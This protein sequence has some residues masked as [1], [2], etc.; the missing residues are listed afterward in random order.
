M[1]SVEQVGIV[2]PLLDVVRVMLNIVYNQ[3][4]D[5]HAAPSMTY[6]AMVLFSA[7]SSPS[8]DKH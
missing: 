3:Y 7:A 2:T 4:T 6:A 8:L 1:R 5:K